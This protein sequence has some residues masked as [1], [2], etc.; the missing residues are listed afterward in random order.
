MAVQSAT[1]PETLQFNVGRVL[2]VAAGLFA[3]NFFVFVAIHLAISIPS[4]AFSFWSQSLLAP[5]EQGYLGPHR[6]IMLLGTLVGF[7]CGATAQA[8]LTYGAIQGLGG[9]EITIGGSLRRGLALAPKAAIAFF[10]CW[11]MIAV[12]MI[13]LVIPGIIVAAMLWVYLPAIVVE[14]AGVFECFGRSRFLTKGHRW[15]IFG[16]FMLAV[17]IYGIVELLLFK[18]VGMENLLVLLHSPLVMVVVTAISLVV[19]TYVAIATAVGY[20]YLRAEKEGASI[21]V[22]RVFE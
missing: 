2:S 13:F 3:R 12:P 8:A 20:Y 16:L 6:D 19:L 10:L 17:V 18:T 22:A 21:H 14:N 7:V 1:S 4:Y 5:G 11:L 15:Q 9:E